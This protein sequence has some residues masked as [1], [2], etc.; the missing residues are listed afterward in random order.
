MTSEQ[1]RAEHDEAA[2]PRMSPEEQQYI[3]S[4]PITERPLAIYGLQTANMHYQAGFIWF[5]RS[6]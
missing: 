6:R 5:L 1:I 2:A 3:N 4:L